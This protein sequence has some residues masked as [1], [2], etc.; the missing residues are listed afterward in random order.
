[1]TELSALR[2]AMIVIALS[3]LAVRPVVG[4][5]PSDPA[6]PKV[7][8]LTP[9]KAPGTAKYDRVTFT[10]APKALP[11]GAVTQDWPTFLG[12]AG[13]AV[14]TETKLL[15]KFPTGGMKPVW[16]LSKGIGYASPSIQGDY[17]VFP[18]RVKNEVI[19]ECLHPAT[20]EK[21]WEYRYPTEYEDRYGYGSGPRASPVIDGDRVYLLGVEGQFFCLELATGRTIWERNI[22]KEFK[23]PQD[24]F[25][26]VGTPLLEGDLLII[27]VGAP[28]GPCVA[29]FNKITGKAVWQAG[30]KWGPSYAS[31]IPGTIHGQ[32]RVF[33]LA[34]GESNPAI[35]GL[36]S[37][38]PKNGKVDFEFPFRSKKYE[39]VNASPPLVVGDTVMVSATY[40]TGT[41]LLKL[42]TDFKPSTVWKMTDREHNEGENEMGLHWTTPVFKDGYVYAF[43]GRNEPDASLVCV[44]HAK[45]KV[46]WRKVPEWKETLKLNGE[47][48][49]MDL[50]T[51]RGNILLVDGRAL[52]LGELGHLLWL[53]LNPNGYKELD[54]TWL[55]AARETWALP[56][57]SRGLLYVT[58][59]TPDLMTRK[60][61]RLLCYDLRGTE[62]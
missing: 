37:I 34:G 26:T 62:E 9:M 27:N 60:G 24:F 14:S 47:S 61:P 17:L 32:R 43:D 10:A 35:G 39:S 55:F 19:V 16:E 20:G 42:G 54:R 51:L 25:G 57:V 33:V 13:K 8:S 4:A 58:Q 38:D 31:P 50:S 56:V 45:G 2:S 48:Q 36:L 1:M 18:H 15:K 28:D 21:Y 40:R 11:K 49:V 29:A 3:G 44:D 59:N 46:V 41:T 5:E 23:V 30:D 52:A 22:N 7:Q 53:D 6:P 12:R